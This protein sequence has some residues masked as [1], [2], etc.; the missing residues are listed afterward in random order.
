MFFWEPRLIHRLKRIHNKNIYPYNCC[1]GKLKACC[2]IFTTLIVYL[3][4]LL[5]ILNFE[6]NLIF[7]LSILQSQLGNVPLGKS[8]ES[9]STRLESGLDCESLSLYTWLKW[10]GSLW[11]WVELFHRIRSWIRIR[12]GNCADD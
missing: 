7:N 6:H 4:W 11:L 12:K 9:T 3:F 8:V 2:F 1:D 5:I 10:E